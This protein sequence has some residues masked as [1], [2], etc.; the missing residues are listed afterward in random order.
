[1]TRFTYAYI[2]NTDYIINLKLASHKMFYG[3]SVNTHNEASTKQ[4]IK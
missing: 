1:M 3:G 4:N 2:Y